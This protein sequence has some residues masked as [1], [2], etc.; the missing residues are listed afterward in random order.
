MRHAWIVVLGLMLVACRSPA[1]IGDS[2]DGIV[3]ARP[4][5]GTTKAQS[6]NIWYRFAYREGDDGMSAAVRLFAPPARTRFFLPGE[7]AGRGDFAEVIG[8]TGASTS[9]GPADIEID[10][11]ARHVDVVSEG[12]RWVE[13]QYRVTFSARSAFHA[14]VDSDVLVAF[15]PTVV[16][17]PASQIL[18]RSANIP[19]ELVLPSS[20]ELI[21]TWPSHGRAESV[22]MPGHTVHKFVAKD[23][24][25]LRDAFFVAGPQLR[26]VHADSAD[27][28]VAFSPAFEGDSDELAAVVARVCQIY[29][30][31]FGDAGPIRVFV[32]TR[33]SQV[34]ELG[35]TGRRG[36]F[37]LDVP[38]DSAVTDEMR[39]L[40]A[41]EALHM[42]NG[43]LAMPTADADVATRWF[44]EGVTHYLALKLAAQASEDFV[45]KELAEIGSA[46]ARNPISRGASARQADVARF[47]YDFGALVALTIDAQITLAS[48]GRSD[49]TCW[50]TSLLERDD[51]TYD[52]TVLFDALQACTGPASNRDVAQTWRR[53]IRVR[54]PMN[55]RK[56]F[57]AIGLHWLPATEHRS[58]QLVPLDGARPLYRELFGLQEHRD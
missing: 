18:E 5:T 15:G 19:V 56:V 20:R 27:L 55:L 31:R 38:P 10:R 3:G 57:E 52:E 39:L 53:L 46:Y 6:A 51:R 50:L 21:S 24:G 2:G 9:V 32:R 54:T 11:H 22:A 26:A 45:L 49:I 1:P 14:Q 4:D 34:G 40:V 37:V 36:G 7:W 29:R 42:W 35:G 47:P 44:K 48:R 12:A 28:S 30:S 13:L 43:H 25:Q 23:I 16:V 33:A 41:H 58:A 17:T 8:I